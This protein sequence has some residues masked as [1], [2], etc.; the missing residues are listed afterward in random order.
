MSLVRKNEFQSY[1]QGERKIISEAIEECWRAIQVWDHREGT[2][3]RMGQWG[4]AGSYRYW[5]SLHRAV[6]YLVKFITSL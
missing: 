1:R 2:L 4:G 6:K 5:R 3:S